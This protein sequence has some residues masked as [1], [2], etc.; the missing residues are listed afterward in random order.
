MRTLEDTLY[1]HHRNWKKIA[2]LITEI[3]GSGCIHEKRELELKKKLFN[4]Q[5]RFNYVH[6]LKL[7]H[8]RF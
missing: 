8:L 3:S 6:I 5:L 2:F 1:N 4:D 7:K